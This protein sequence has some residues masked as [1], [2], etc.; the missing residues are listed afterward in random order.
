M[1]R[2][3]RA[4]KEHLNEISEI[5]VECFYNRF[6]CFECDKNKLIK[7]FKH[8]FILSKFYVVLMDDRVIGICGVS[9]GNSTIKFKKFL[10]CYHLGFKLGNRV[11]KYLKIILEDKDYAFEMDDKCGLIEYL[12]IKEEYRNKGIGSTLVNHVI[13]DNNYVRYIAK[14]ADNN[15]ALSFFEK[16]YFEEFDREKASEKE[17]IDIGVND[18]LYMICEKR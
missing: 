5:F 7:L 3:V 9:D 8:I 16:L 12:G 17:R 13:Y 4:N 2:I 10:F 6:K 15:S 14:V 1:I 11:Y 18:Y